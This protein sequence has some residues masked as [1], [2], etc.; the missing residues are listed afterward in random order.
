MSTNTRGRRYVFMPNPIEPLERREV[1]SATPIPAD[2]RNLSAT[3]VGSAHAVAIHLTGPGDREVDFA[4]SGKDTLRHPI[5]LSGSL[6]TY[7]PA[8]YAYIPG[9]YG[10]ATLTTNRGTYHFNILGPGSD[11][12]A[13]SGISNLKFSIA[14]PGKAPNTMGTISPQVVVAVGTLQ[15]HRQMNPDG[16]EQVTASIIASAP[17]K[18]RVRKS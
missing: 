16:S 18:V 2:L 4:A 17:W 12:N 13:G 11:L 3:V 9:T 14:K 5:S 1:L 15:V 8:S 10:S 7:D 6:V